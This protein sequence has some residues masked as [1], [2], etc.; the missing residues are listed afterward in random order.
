M[1]DLEFIQ[2]TKKL[3][4]PRIN[5]FSEVRKKLISKWNH[6]NPEKLKASQKKYSLTTKGKIANMR[7]N[8]TR[9]G[10]YKESCKGLSAQD[11]ECIKNFYINRPDG[12]EV[13]HII[14]LSKGGNHHISNLQYLT[15]EENRKKNNKIP[16]LTPIRKKCL[17]F[18]NENGF[19]SISNIMRKTKLTYIKSF[20]ICEW[21]SSLEHVCSNESKTILRIK[22]KNFYGEI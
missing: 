7:R 4:E 17:S 21:L 14:P 6:E 11:L 13:D 10:R 16:E 2:R 9:S 1:V 15:R 5:E 18:L 12:Y 3:L 20:E 8:C 22:K 19:A